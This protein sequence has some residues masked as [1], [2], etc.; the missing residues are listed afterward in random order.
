MNVYGYLKVHKTDNATIYENERSLPRAMLLRDVIIEPDSDRMLDYMA[1]L[2]FNPKKEILFEDDVD[3]SFLNN[4]SKTNVRYDLVNIEKYSPREV[5]IAVFAR[6]PAFLQ[7]ADAYYPGWIAYLD[8][9]K[10]NILRSDYALRAIKVP[11]GTH[12]VRFVYR[13]FS[14]Y[15]GSA[16]TLL[17]LILL[18]IYG[19][20]R[21]FK[22]DRRLFF[23]YNH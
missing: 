21:V 12:R 3:I 6:T 5:C 10:Q 15:M 9:K 7:L 2:K 23:K 4:K 11:A 16:T 13:P 18:I 19:I 8:G 1:S 22:I 20:Y 17:S 14:F